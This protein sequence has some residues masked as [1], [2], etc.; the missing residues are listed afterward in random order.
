M[1]LAIGADFHFWRASWHLGDN[2]IVSFERAS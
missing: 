1:G 2:T